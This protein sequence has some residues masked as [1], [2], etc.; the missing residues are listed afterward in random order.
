M[1]AVVS[2]A[3]APMSMAAT[4]CGSLCGS[5]AASMLCKACSCRCV[6]SQKVASIL[7]ISI[8]MGFVILALFFKY[9]GGDITIGGSSNSTE[10]SILDKA[11]KAS[12]QGAMKYWNDR[13]YCAPAHPDALLIICC[14]NRCAGVYAVYRF[15]FVLCLF[16]AFLL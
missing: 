1:G 15:S 14:A 6:A 13:F 11:A 5:C 12:A 2:L 10:E 8:L 16:F 3:S 9:E 7:Y 4:C